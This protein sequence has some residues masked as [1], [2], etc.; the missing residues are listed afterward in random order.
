MSLA[1]FCQ[2]IC[3]GAGT[4]RVRLALSIEAL[5]IGTTTQDQEQLT[6]VAKRSMH[7]SLVNAGTTE[8]ELK[9]LPLRVIED[10]SC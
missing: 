9:E 3:C 1:S 10:H 7:P 2:E 5:S 8:I 6:E 4:V